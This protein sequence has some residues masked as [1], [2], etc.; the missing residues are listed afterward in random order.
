MSST[1]DLVLVLAP[2]ATVTY[3]S[4]ASTSLLGRSPASL[5]GRP[6]SQLVGSDG[7]AQLLKAL[8]AMSDGAQLTMELRATHH[9]GRRIPIELSATSRLRDA[10]ISGYVVSIRDTSE[11]SQLAAQLARQAM[12][13]PLTGLPNR[14]LFLSMTGEEL[15]AGQTRVTVVMADLV[16]FASINTALGHAAADEV[17]KEVGRRL[18]RVAGDEAVL[19]RVGGDEF[20]LLLADGDSCNLTQLTTQLMDA[21]CQPVRIG[22]GEVRPHL[23]LG[24]AMCLDPAQT[25]EDLLRNG[26]AAV[27]SAKAT[28]ASV[29]RYDEDVHHREIDRVLLRQDLEAA[30][31]DGDLKL[32]FQPIVDLQSGSIRG[33]EALAR[34]KHRD[35]GFVSPGEFVPLAERSGLMDELGEW[36]LHEACAAASRLQQTGR[37]IIMSVNVS[38]VQLSR[39]NFVV[40]LLGVLDEFQL[41][42]DCLLLEITETAVVVGLDEVIPRLTALRSIGVHVSMDD[43]G[44]G[45]SSLNY[46]S[47]LPLDELKIDK[48]FVE[49]LEWDGQTQSVIRGM[50]E[51]SVNLGLLTVGEGIETQEQADWLSEAGCSLGQGFLFSRPLDEDQIAV[52]L[53]RLDHVPAQ[54]RRDAPAV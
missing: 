51:M 14:R 49:R 29:A 27:A 6:I 40:D 37:R 4:A 33:V 13:D 7:A 52:A 10:V 2:D 21:V 46:L 20:G 42:P 26:E 47:R 38:A 17:L 34:W 54:V 30:I 48:S 45:Y 9:D 25:A 44:T 1:S 19:A 8:R 35:R 22:T 15:R 32:V 24:I 43:F 23:C 18:Q 39:P 16:D 41:E 11:I 5:R 31:H 36:I 12:L 28:G 53:T 3:C 50:L